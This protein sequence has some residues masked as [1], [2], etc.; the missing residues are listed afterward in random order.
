MT[1]RPPNTLAALLAIA[2]AVYGIAFWALTALDSE[3]AES[4]FDALRTSGAHGRAVGHGDRALALHREDGIGGDDIQVLMLEVA[5]SHDAGGDPSRAATLYGDVLASAL[6]SQMSAAERMAIKRRMATLYLDTDQPVP[7]AII[8]AE[9]VDL[10]GDLAANPDAEGTETEQT[11]LAD[12]LAARDRF[13]DLLPPVP[14][15]EVITGTERE[16]LFAA[17]R[18]TDL[19]GFYASQGEDGAYA[20][21]GLLAAAYTT[22]LDILTADHPDT[23]QTAL[24]LGPVYER[25]GR[26]SDAERVYLTAFHAQER[27]KGSNNPELSLYIRLLVDVYQRQGRYTEAEALNVHM[28]NLFR[29]AF[30]ARRYAGRDRS[31]DVNRPVSVDFKLGGDYRPTDLVRAADYDIPLSKDPGLEEMMIR[32]APVDGKTMPVMLREL[33][34]ACATQEERLTLRS[35]YRSYETQV[36]LFRNSASGKVTEP[37]TSEH[38][39]GLAADIDVNGRFMRSTDRAFGCFEARAFQYG[40]ILSYPPGNKYLTA[41]DAFEPWHWRF[42]GPKTALL[43]REIGPLGRPQEFLAALPCYQERA[44]SGL[45]ISADEE[46]LCLATVATADADAEADGKGSEG[47]RAG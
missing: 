1:V 24:L 20:A 4:R 35:G 14:T 28:R 31:F 19:G 46:D 10:A 12:A 21:A 36:T 30:G 6:G 15:A 11:Y 26:L 3:S 42:V 2:I 40:F 13:T 38:Q 29:D 7:A 33:I 47:S 32:R 17:G 22:R 41:D 44:L 45:F 27:S 5:R 18:L 9:L 25:M 34:N 39:L 23:V 43:Y 8:V 16:R 37:G